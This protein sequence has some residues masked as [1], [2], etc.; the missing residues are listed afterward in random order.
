MQ[1]IILAAG[2]GKRM[3]SDIP[4][5][6]QLV[7]SK[8]MIINIINQ[9]ILLKP[10]VIII[11]VNSESGKLIQT[12]IDNAYYLKNSDIFTYVVQD[13]PQGTG[14][15]IQCVVNAIENND[16]QPTMIINGDTPL[17]QYATLKNIY[18]NFIFTAS[19]LQV[20][21]INLINPASN[22]R[23]V[24]INNKIKI[25]EEKDCNDEERLITLVNTGIYVADF[26]LLKRHIFSITNENSQNEYYLT[27]IVA[28]ASN[29]TLYVLPSAKY[30]EI[31]NVNDKEQLAFVNNLD[32][33]LNQLSQKNILT[34]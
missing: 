7:H 6:L 21:G 15:A 27:D 2:Y 31:Y 10:S 29:T 3:N 22:G 16:N 12:T 1:V 32:F 26:E 25:I 9:V 30:H 33:D 14:H 23:I 8:P 17:I 19:S 20:V 28:I 18:N 11:V 5:V 13:K 4:K 24:N 34:I